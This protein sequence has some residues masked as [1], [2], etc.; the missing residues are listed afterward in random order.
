MVAGGGRF[1]SR[2]VKK[3]LLY[4]KSEEWWLVNKKKLQRIVI[5]TSPRNLVFLL[6]LKPVLRSRNYLFSAL[7]PTLAIISA[8]A[9]AP[10]PGTAIYWHL[11]LF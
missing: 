7:A 4:F 9:P 10:A 5:L 8:P 3:S 11:K 1:K 6:C 2:H